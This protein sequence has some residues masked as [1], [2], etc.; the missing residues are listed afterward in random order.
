MIKRQYRRGEYSYFNNFIN[1]HDPNEVIEDK[2]KLYKATIAK[3]KNKNYIMNVKWHDEKMYSL[4]VL[5][6]A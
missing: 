2:L 5:R 1:A 3:S 4:F 6:W